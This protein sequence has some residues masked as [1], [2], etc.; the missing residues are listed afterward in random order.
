MSPWLCLPQWLCPVL[1]GTWLSRVERTGIV[2]CPWGY[3]PQEAHICPGS[4]F[5]L[6]GVVYTYNLILLIICSSQKQTHLY[7]YPL[8]YN[9]FTFCFIIYFRE[10]T[11]TLYHFLHPYC[12][13]KLQLISGSDTCPLRRSLSV[14]DC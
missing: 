2:V 6:C 10:K 4:R 1:W 7:F 11:F 9:S 14:H 3:G 12:R 5:T 8:L 13:I